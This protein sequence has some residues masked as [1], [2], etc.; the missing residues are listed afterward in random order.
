M[1]GLKIILDIVLHM[2]KYLNLI[3]DKFGVFSYVILFAVIFCETGLVVAPFLPGDSLIF[4]SGAL[5][6][7]GSFNI[8]VLFFILAAAA[9]LGDSL[10]Y[11]LGHYFGTKAF[12]NYPRIF[13]KKYLDRTH[14][15]FEKYGAKTI[16]LG[17]F[18]PIVRT[19]APFLAGVDG[20]QYGKFITYNII[21]GLIWVSLFL[22]GGYF[23]GTISFVKEHFSLVILFV[24][25]ASFIPLIVDYL[26]HK[27]S[28]KKNE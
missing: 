1:S 7:T 15:F 14:K 11:W 9:I 16:V 27:L 20:M 28:K 24:I 13:K 4:T 18:F 6:A 23:F 22:F 5:A 12:N 10:N 2:D 19:F 21:G 25:V 26:R 3:I 17:R 8:I